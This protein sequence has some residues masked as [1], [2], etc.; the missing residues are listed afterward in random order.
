[1]CRFSD[2]GKDECTTQWSD[3]ENE[4]L[5]SLNGKTDLV[6]INPSFENHMGLYIC[7]SCC[8]NHCQ[9][10]TSFVYPVRFSLRKFFILINLFCRLDKTSKQT[11]KLIFV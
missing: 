8:H 1:M 6:L 7:Q 3:P 9:I 2:N 11:I 4:P 10:L 5:D